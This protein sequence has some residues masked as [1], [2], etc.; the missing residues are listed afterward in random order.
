M[1]FTLTRHVVNDGVLR[2]QL[3]GDV[4]LTTCDEVAEAI[5]DAIVTCNAAELIIDLGAVG[6]LDSTGIRAL[7][8]GRRLAEEHGVA[9]WVTN[10]RD[11]VRTVLTVVGV[12]ET[13][14]AT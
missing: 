12:L 11:M 7:V 14:P 1:D 4:D 10:A 13:R 6:F 5:H 9:Y 2:L 8:I 3:A